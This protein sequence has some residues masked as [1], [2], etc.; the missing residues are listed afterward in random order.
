MRTRMGNPLYDRLNGPIP[1]QPQ[2]PMNPLMSRFG[3]MANFMQM[4]NAYAS[5]QM[6]P[7]NPETMVKNMLQNG[8]ITQDQFNQAAMMA[9]QLTGRKF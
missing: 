5:G 8:Q 6:G 4:Y 9:N 3:S 7:I 2:Q 1:Q